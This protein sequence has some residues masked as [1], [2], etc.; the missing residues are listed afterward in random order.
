MSE[1]APIRIII[2]GGS[3]QVGCI[4]ARHFHT[5]GHTVTVLSRGPRPAPWR[6]MR[7]DGL[8]QGAWVTELEQSD[9]CI[10]LAG[11]SV[12]CRYSANNRRAI[13]KSRIR[14]AILLN[15]VIASLNQP[16]RLWV[17][18][19]TAT[20]YR[21]ALNRAMDEATGELGGN[22]AGAADTWNFFIEIAKGWEEAFFSTSTHAPARS[23]CAVR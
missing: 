3:G 17:N 1:L 7:W 15:Q 23:P 6:V 2:P 22:E 18:A 14:S 8:T 13:F 9:I 21:H 19:S 11:R 20:I 10:N 12:N 5:T 4:L 16:P